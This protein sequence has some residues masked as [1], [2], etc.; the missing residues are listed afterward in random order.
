MGRKHCID[1]S[2][3][4]CF[5]KGLRTQSKHH[6]FMNTNIKKKRNADGSYLVTWKV[7]TR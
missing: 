7:Y 5:I 2:T 4:K 1:A 3:A 6:T